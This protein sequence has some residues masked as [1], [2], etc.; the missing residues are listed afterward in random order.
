MSATGFA[1][2]YGDYDAIAMTSVRKS[3]AVMG[4]GAHLTAGPGNIW[5]NRKT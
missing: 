3:V 4:E 5:F 2:P 1:A